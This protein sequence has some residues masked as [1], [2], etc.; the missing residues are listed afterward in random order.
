MKKIL[1]ILLC[2]L[3]IMTLVACGGDKDKGDDETDPPVTDTTPGDGTES[4]GTTGTETPPENT[5]PG[6]TTG[7]ENPPEDSVPNEDID[8][9]AVGFED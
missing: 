9:P 2:I 8:L 7:T 6:E 3:L 5:E 1:A 4:G